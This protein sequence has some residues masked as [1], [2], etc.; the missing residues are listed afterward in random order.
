MSVTLNI[1]RGSYFLEFPALDTE[2][3][4]SDL[5]VLN[6]TVLLELRDMGDAE[7]GHLVHPLV[8][9]VIETVHDEGL[10]KAQL[11]KSANL[12]ID[13]LPVGYTHD[14]VFGHGGVEQ[15][16]YQVNGRT[17][18]DLGQNAGQGPGMDRG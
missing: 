12:D 4:R 5:V 14:L 9:V 6:G 13:H 3:V 17:E 10:F 8:R 15:R 18:A 11:L 7:G 2:I 1:P 16:T